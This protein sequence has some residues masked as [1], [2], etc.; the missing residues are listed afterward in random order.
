[1]QFLKGNN[2]QAAVMRSGANQLQV[3]NLEQ[4]Q[5]KSGEVL[6]RTGAAGLCASDIHIIH[7]TAQVPLPCVLGHEGAGTVEAIGE[8]VTN[9]KPGDRCVLSFVS[10]C[11]HCRMCRSGHPHLCDINA[12][13]GAKQFDGTTRLTDQNGQEVFQMSKLGV[14]SE[15]QVAPAQA[16]Y[17]MPD[18]V[19]MEVAALIGC[20][21]TT[22]V[23]SVINAPKARAG[24]TVVVIGAGGVGINAIQGARLMNASRIIVVDI[25]EHKLEFAT[26]FGAT[27]IIDATT[28]SATDAILELTNGGVDLALDTFGGI[29]TTQQAIGSLRK[30]GVAVVVGLAALGDK[31][32]IDL[33]D[34]V[35]MQKTVTGAYYGLAS[36]HETFRT[37]IELYLKGDLLIDEIIE[38]RYNLEEINEGFEALERGENGRGVLVFN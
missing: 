26:R 6:I 33:V 34:I 27:D 10:N 13:S 36:P 18:D 15:Y 1:M 12:L 9:V 3:E 29:E 16:C 5:P 25:A 11:G 17:P 19:P 4:E 14:F 37:M 23:G 28:T 8:G 20:S 21:V 32:N 35:R 31:A 24:M 30:N 22:G 7:G 2:M 38:R